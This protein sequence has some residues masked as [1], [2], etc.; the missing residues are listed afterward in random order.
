[1]GLLLLLIPVPVKGTEQSLQLAG[2]AWPRRATPSLLPTIC[3]GSAVPAVLP[4]GV[5]AST[6]S[7][8]LLPCCRRPQWQNDMCLL[9][10]RLCSRVGVD[11]KELI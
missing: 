11:A 6:R 4:R 1:M 8:L 2:Q 9:Q 10:S 7:L 5:K 3:L